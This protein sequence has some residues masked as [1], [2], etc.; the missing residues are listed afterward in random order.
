MKCRM[1]IAFLLSTTAVFSS[2]KA[3][4]NE[5]KPLTTETGTEYKNVNEQHFFI[6]STKLAQKNQNSISSGRN[7]EYYDYFIEALE[8]KRAAIL[9]DPEENSKAESS[10]WFKQIDNEIAKAKQLRAQL[11]EVNEK[12]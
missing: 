10:G 8:T 3:Q 7:V 9:N 2:I 12:H 1:L 4:R 5:V 6:D 11:L